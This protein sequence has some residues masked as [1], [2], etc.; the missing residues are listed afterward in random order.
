LSTEDPEY[1]V[2]AEELVDWSVEREAEFL[3][4]VPPGY[5]NQ[6]FLVA[7]RGISWYA[8]SRQRFE[9]ALAAARAQR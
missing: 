2:T 3:V 6:V 8:P 5:A 1:P 4:Y 7:D 9:D